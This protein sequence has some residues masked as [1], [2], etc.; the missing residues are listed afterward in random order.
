[1]VSVKRYVLTYPKKEGKIVNI[2]H[3]DSNGDCI[4]RFQ[5]GKRDVYHISWLKEI[6]Q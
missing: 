1:M 2:L 5:N 4:I 3:M 6:K